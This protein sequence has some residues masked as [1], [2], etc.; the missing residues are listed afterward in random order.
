[1]WGWHSTWLLPWYAGHQVWSQRARDQ[2]AVNH[3]S[4]SAQARVRS[5][6]QQEYKQAGDVAQR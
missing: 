2:A 3:A 5:H 4:S 1:M 6:G